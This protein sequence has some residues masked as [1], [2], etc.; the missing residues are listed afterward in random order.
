MSGTSCGC[1]H[2]RKNAQSFCFLLDGLDSCCGWHGSGS[3]SHGPIS[4][5]KTR[6]GGDDNTFL[7]FGNSGFPFHCEFPR[8]HERKILFG[9]YPYFWGKDRGLWK[10]RSQVGRPKL[11]P[12]TL[13]LKQL[14]VN[15]LSSPSNREHAENAR[16]KLYSRTPVDS[17]RYL[18][19]NSY[20]Q[21]KG[22]YGHSYIDD[23]LPRSRESD[24]RPCQ[25]PNRY[26]QNSNDKCNWRPARA[27]RP[28]GNS[29]ERQGK[30]VP[31]MRNE[32]LRVACSV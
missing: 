23:Q 29:P 3:G 24:K 13:A 17:Y 14:R 12:D 2:H 32:R 30:S 9:N 7:E 1:R 20:H 25:S 10:D 4:L 26:Q 28:I 31:I 22:N 18:G 27:S 6:V 19:A 15:P 5:K 16:F 8:G 11:P 21:R